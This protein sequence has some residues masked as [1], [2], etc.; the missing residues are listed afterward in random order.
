MGCT[1]RKACFEWFQV[2]HVTVTTKNTSFS[3]RLNGLLTS[4][5]DVLLICIIKSSLYDRRETESCM[6]IS[7]MFH[8]S[9][10][11]TTTTS[12]H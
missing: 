1:D 6:L 8:L 2:R 11:Y 10:T 4:I 3:Q 5:E 7:L 12:P 9:V